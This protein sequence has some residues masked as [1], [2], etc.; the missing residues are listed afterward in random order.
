MRQL[1]EHFDDQQQFRGRGRRDA[2]GRGR[3]FGGHGMGGRGFPGQRQGRRRRGD[4]RTALLALLA[5]GAGHGYDL[6]NRLEER[7]GGAWRPSPGS[8]YPTL[9]LL[10]DEDLVTVAEDDGK[11]VYTITDAGREEAERRMDDADGAPWATS[12][13]HPGQLFRAFG[14]L[15][16]AAKQIAA[17]GS[18]TQLTAAIGII[19]Q[20][21]QKMYQ[22]LA[23]GDQPADGNQLADEAQG[24]V[25]P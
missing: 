3:S 9:Q 21:R 22:L 2:G 18:P 25:N 7:S 11:R 4:V 1:H 5:E 13:V 16:M 23:D 17:A 20:A 24:D 6:I 10:E 12:G 14:T 15:G 8:I 19:D